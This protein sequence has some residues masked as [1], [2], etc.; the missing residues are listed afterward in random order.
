MAGLARELH[1]MQHVTACVA[2]E[3][4]APLCDA[5]ELR[6]IRADSDRSS[7]S[8]RRWAA[9]AA[10]LLQLHHL[11]HAIRTFAPDVLVASPFGYG[12]ALA[13]EH[14]RLPLVVLGG[15][16]HL[17]QVG[18]ERRREGL[19]WY[20][21]GRRAAGLPAH[22]GDGH[23]PWLGDLFLLQGTPALSGANEHEDNIRHV[24]DCTWDPPE[25]RDPVLLAWLAARDSTVPLAYVQCGREFGATPVLDNLTLAAKRLGIALAID[26]G[27][28]DRP[29]SLDGEH[30]YARPFVAR[31]AVLP[32]ASLV[33][34]S[35]QPSSVL[36]ALAHGLPLV[37]LPHGSGTEETAD[38]CVR[39][40]VALARQLTQA[41]ADVLTASIDET[42]SS[43]RMREAARATGRDIARLGGLRRAARLITD[44]VMKRSTQFDRVA[45][46]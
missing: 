2:N 5:Y 42:L 39:A 46:L 24:G 31:S 14:H 34:T 10:T 40:G 41:T 29:F 23:A 37:L 16:V 12:P 22:T 21:A 17:W 4:I 27:R 13:A 11:E 1:G 38:A 7:F 15:L 45:L 30:V 20:S 9:P 44:L 25:C 43:A 19:E 33:I 6:R 8:L 28:N 32:L 36:A 18:T 35:G 26:T 3:R